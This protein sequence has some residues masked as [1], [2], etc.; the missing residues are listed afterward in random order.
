[1]VYPEVARVRTKRCRVLPTVRVLI[2]R[3]I[4]LY[5][6]HTVGAQLRTTPKFGGQLAKPVL[7]GYGSVF[8]DPQP[9]RPVPY[10]YQNCS[11]TTTP[12]Q[13]NDAAQFEPEIWSAFLGCWSNPTRPPSSKT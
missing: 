2:V 4:I 3:H 1:M 7:V 6:P 8:N 13:G 12:N 5:D 9:G 11:D 10:Q